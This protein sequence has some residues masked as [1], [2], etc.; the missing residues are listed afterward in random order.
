MYCPLESHDNEIN[1]WFS[2]A[3]M[4]LAHVSYMEAAERAQTVYMDE[5]RVQSGLVKVSQELDGCIGS[6]EFYLSLYS[7]VTSYPRSRLF[8][9]STPVVSGAIPVLPFWI[10]RANLASLYKDSELKQ[11][12]FSNTCT[13][14]SCLRSIAT[15]FWELLE[16]I[17]HGRLFFGP[18]L[19]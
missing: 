18:C 16:S 14:Y 19:Q 2:F 4:L 10:Y 7:G 6:L 9:L 3:W 13:S 15:V 1:D 8:S 11:T 17:F 12:C 5:L